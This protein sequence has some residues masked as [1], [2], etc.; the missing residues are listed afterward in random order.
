[1]KQTKHF[2]NCSAALCKEGIYQNEA[3]WYIGEEVCRKSPFTDWQQKQ[4]LLNK[5]LKLGYK[6]DLRMAYT[7]ASLERHPQKVPLKMGVKRRV[8]D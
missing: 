8:L 7:M 5:K 2:K 6:L 1:M 3:V 4:M